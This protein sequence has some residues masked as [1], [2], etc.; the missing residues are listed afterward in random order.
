M[1]WF[2]LVQPHSL[3]L[4]L[5]HSAVG[6]RAW[7]EHPAGVQLSHRT[8]IPAHAVRT[9]KRMK[10]PWQGLADKLR[11]ARP[12]FLL[13]KSK[14]MMSPNRLIRVA[15]RRQPTWTTHKSA[16]LLERPASENCA[17]SAGLL[18]EDTTALTPTQESLV[19]GIRNTVPEDA[20]LGLVLLAM[21]GHSLLAHHDSSRIRAS[22][23]S[24]TFPTAFARMA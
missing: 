24:E 10:R 22:H 2:C 4:C 19:G 12:S 5:G 7:Q 23:F 3:T 15:L 20:G 1:R 11:S 13:Q 6:T 9:C 8:G 18:A 17:G 14:S 16:R 21:R